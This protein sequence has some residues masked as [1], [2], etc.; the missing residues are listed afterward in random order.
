MSRT[1]LLSVC[2]FIT[3]SCVFAQENV[4]SW[5]NWRGPNLNAVASSGNPPTEW[6][7]ED[8]KNIKWKINL[9]GKGSSS[10]IVWKDRIYLTTAIPT[11]KEGKPAQKP[12]EEGGGRGGFGGSRGRSG[13]RSRGRRGRGGF[14]SGRAPTAVHDFAV[15]AIDRATGKEVWRKVVKSVVPHA[16]THNHGTQASNSPLTDGEHIYAHFGSRG[17][18]CLD[19]NGKIKWSKDL[20]KMTTRNSFGEGSSPALYGDTIVVIWDHERQS[21]IAAF[22]KKTGRQRWKKSRD[23]ASG[24]ATPLIVDVG[25]KPQVIIPATKS[26]KAYDLK[27]GRVIWRCSG[28]T[29]NVIPT[30]IYQDGMVYLMSGFRGNALQA[31]RI[32]GARG[33][34]SD[35]KRIVWSHNRNCPYTPSGLLYDGNLFFM[36]TNS[37]IL[38]C[39]DAKTGEVRYEG[40]RLRGVNTVYSSPVAVA[41]RIYITGR[42]GTTKVVKAGNDFELLATNKLDDTIDATAAIVG[43]ELYLR[44][45]SKLY[46]IAEKKKGE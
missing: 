36:R 19:M 5:G 8:G 21:F 23:E 41:G 46:C 11:G 10:P 26:S 17:L 13:R 20:G 16:G 24:W 3:A 32:K 22:N 45:W 2:V 4:A 35:S 30:P 27:S 39:L 40:E 29:G 1:A 25:G 14:G 28:L 15:L 7:E 31:I 37:A 44:G 12:P 9:P 18:H 34:L 33:D 43:D 6:N 38:S 42:M